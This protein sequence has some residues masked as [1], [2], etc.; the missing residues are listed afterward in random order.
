VVPGLGFSSWLK[1]FVANL[2]VFPMTGLL[3]ALSFVF[4]NTAGNILGGALF[5]FKWQELLGLI[6][7]GGASLGLIFASNTGWPP[8]IGG[9]SAML[10][11]IF[12]G[13]SFMIFTLV[14][15]AAD[16]IQG[17]I[18][19]RPFAYGTA[20]GEA[21]GPVKGAWGM[22]GAPLVDIA[23]KTEFE[24]RVQGW[25]KTLAEKAEERKKNKQLQNQPRGNE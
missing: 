19:G 10:G 24:T 18:T 11:F 17:F 6:I 20:I 21:F 7:P 2:A 3:L 4:L 5:D 14:P 15:K 25:R 9:S 22:A 8:L 12:V 23:R 13:V 1:A 16:V